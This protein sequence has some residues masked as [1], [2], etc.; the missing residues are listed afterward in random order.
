MNPRRIPF[1]LAA[2]LLLP[3]I[4]VLALTGCLSKPAL[5]HQT[6]SFGKPA[7]TATNSAAGAPV[8]GLKR[9]I[10][11]TPFNDC[12]FT[13]RTGDFSYARD[14]YAGFL[15]APAEELAVPVRTELCSQGDFSDVVTSEGTLKPDILLDVRV[16]RLF[17]DFRQPSGAK[18]VLTM[19]FTFYNASNGVA[20]SRSFQK[21]YS[22]EIPLKKPT[23][24]ALIAG[25]NQALME[26]L[27]EALA[28]YRQAKGH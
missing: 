26:I 18:A 7:L 3:L 16:S 21:E 11:A 4:C 28:D 22:R 5:N 20:T 17:G 13:Y 9:I 23:A 14:P 25:W 19:Q 6:F 24:A 15:G 10:V 8:L 27:N 12:S 2:V 1:R